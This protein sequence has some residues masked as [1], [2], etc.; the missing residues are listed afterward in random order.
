MEN[1][2]RNNP[3]TMIVGKVCLLKIP[4]TLMGENMRLR[5]LMLILLLMTSFGCD[6]LPT[7]FTDIKDVIQNPAAY[8][9]KQVKL[10][11][12]VVNVL[13]IPLIGIKLYSIKD[14][15]AE[16][17]VITD[18]QLPVANQKI[19]I[20]AQVDNAVIVGGQSIG[21]KVKEIKRL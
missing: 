18:G 19:S 21:M 6:Y 5:T 9:G 20:K 1:R 4:I 17:T 8:D 15:T 10:K 12:T 16:I 11:G 2:G 7:G 13:K 14:N 3:G